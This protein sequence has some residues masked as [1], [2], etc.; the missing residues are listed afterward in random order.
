MKKRK[1]EN[2][3]RIGELAKLANVSERTIDYYTSLGLIAPAQRSLKNYRLYNDETLL[4]LKR[5][6]QMKSEKYSLDE[7]RDNLNEWNKVT[8]EEQM[9]QR[10][11][12]L[13]MHMQQ[14]E[15][16]VKELSPIIDQM[17]PRQAKHLFKNLTPQSAAVIEALLLLLGKGPFM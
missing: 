7:I 16:E 2:L 14:L 4:R 6:I 1:E 13:Q 9:S 5:I 11:T 3:Y 15:R 10:F 8:D 17:K 12:A